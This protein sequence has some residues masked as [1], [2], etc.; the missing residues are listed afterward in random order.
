MGR[1]PGYSPAPLNLDA[2]VD[3]PPVSLMADGHLVI[4]DLLG[5]WVLPE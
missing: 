2:V 1:C 5:T 3:G 4:F